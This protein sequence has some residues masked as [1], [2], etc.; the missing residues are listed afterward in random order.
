MSPSS[1]RIQ[2]YLHVVSFWECRL[3]K[4]FNLV[5]AR[6]DARAV[7]S[8]NENVAL[9][10]E[11]LRAPKSIRNLKI[12][13]SQGTTLGCS[14]PLGFPGT[15]DASNS[16]VNAFLSRGISEPRNPWAETDHPSRLSPWSPQ[17]VC[18]TASIVPELMHVCNAFSD[19]EAL[20]WDQGLTA[21]LLYR[22]GAETP[23][24]FREKFRVF[25]RMILENFSAVDTQ[26][27][28]L[29]STAEV[30]ISALDTQTPIFLGFLGIHS[31]L[32]F[33]CRETKS[34]GY[35]PEVPVTKI[36]VSA[37]AP[38]KNPTVIIL[39]EL[40]LSCFWK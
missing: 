9:F 21:G 29:V 27:A 19:R 12:R 10:C 40:F 5:P 23:L 11:S 8:S 24:N 30:W 13:A 35:F 16:S 1:T 22:A 6:G 20:P 36:R 31:W 38:Y 15:S 7:R 4:V 33:F 3:L 37:P 18:Y 28:V 17:T 14:P 34:F 25:P 2:F 32:W 26:T 39:H